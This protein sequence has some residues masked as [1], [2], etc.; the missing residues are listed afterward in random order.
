MTRTTCFFVLFALLLGFQSALGQERD[1]ALTNLPGYVD[2]G[3]W[4]GLDTAESTVEVYI[5]EPILG[6]VARLAGE[7]DPELA[8]VLSALKLIRV[9]T[10]SIGAARTPS[11]K[12]EIEEIRKRLQ[13]EHWETVVRAQ[14]KNEQVHVFLK[15]AENKVNGL[16]I[17]AAEYGDEIAFVNIVGDIDL[18][19]IARLGEKFDIPGL[20][21]LKA[22]KP[23]GHGGG[24]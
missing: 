15:S 16:F 22:G 2:L 8:R 18:D 6:L 12:S 1:E 23:S 14:E 10:Y 3:A 19:S 9:Q 7:G 20:D 21:S 13:K 4:A 5:K 11:I 17:V 24:Q